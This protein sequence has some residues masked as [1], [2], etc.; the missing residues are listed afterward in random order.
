[1]CKMQMLSTIEDGCSFGH[2]HYIQH[3]PIT[4]ANSQ[5]LDRL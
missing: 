1:M 2:H 5:S 3:L 4:Y